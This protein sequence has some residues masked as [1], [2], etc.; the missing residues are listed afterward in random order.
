[1]EIIL[2]NPHHN[3]FPKNLGLTYLILFGKKENSNEKIPPS[4]KLGSFFDS[5][6]K[7]GSPF[8]TSKFSTINY[9]K[10]KVGR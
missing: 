7:K 9:D 3:F 6:N 2:S 10:F 1:M 4:I 5:S 8:D